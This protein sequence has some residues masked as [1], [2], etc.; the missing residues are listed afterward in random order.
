MPGLVHLFLIYQVSYPHIQGLGPVQPEAMTKAPHKD[1]F[2]IVVYRL[3][4]LLLVL[5]DGLLHSLS[6]G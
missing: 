5:L 3:L 4:V 1:F 2:L 6:Q